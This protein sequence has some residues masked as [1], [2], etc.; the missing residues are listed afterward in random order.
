MYGPWGIVQ[1]AK[2]KKKKTKLLAQK[3]SSQRRVGI[4]TVG[5]LEVLVK[6]LPHLTIIL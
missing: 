1:Y 4:I 2:K 3:P 5:I 6:D